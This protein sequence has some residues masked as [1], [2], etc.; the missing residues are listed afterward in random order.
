MRPRDVLRSINSARLAALVAL[1]ALVSVAQVPARQ[2]PAELPEMVQARTLFDALD[3]EQAIPMLDRAIM[4][5]EPAAVRDPAV[6]KSLV[7]A[8]EMRARARFGTG[9][10]DGAV[11]DFRA[12]LALNP[13]FT[14]GEGV[15]PRV[16][17]LLDEVKSSTVGILELQ[18]TPGDVS[19]QVDGVAVP[20]SGGKVS[21]A[22]GAHSIKI[23]RPGYKSAEQPVIVTAGQVVPLQLTLE[24]VS[25]VLTVVSSPPD[26]EVFVNGVSRGRTG[27]G[28]VPASLA[29]VPAQ[30]GV[31]ASLVSQPLVI[32]DIPAGTLQVELRR[33]CYA[34][35]HR[36]LPVEG[37]SDVMLDPVKLAP[38]MGALE[39][40]SEPAGATVW[41]DGEQKGLAPITMES[42]CAGTHTIEFRGASGRAVERVVLEAGGKVSVKGRVRP[43]F[44]LLSAPVTG[45]TPDPRLAV[46]RAFAS[47]TNVVLY[48]PPSDAVKAALDKEPV[49]DEWFGLVPGQDPSG[50][51]TERRSRTD[52]LA[53][54]FES[55]G[56]A[57]V[58]PTRPGS[59][60]MQIAL[61]VPGALQPDVLTVVLDQSD[62]VQ[63][64]IS[65]LD[66][67][68]VLS[69]PSLGL[70]VIDVLDV[71]GVVIVDL[72]AGQPGA[73]AGLKPGEILES[74]DGTSVTH[75]A[76][77]DARL[78]SHQPGEKVTLTV[79]AAGANGAS[80]QVP[81]TL[82]RAAAL[83]AGTDRFMPSNAIVAV[84]RSRLAGATEPEDQA[85][86][87]LNLG[88]A[89]LRAGDAQGARSALEKAS[90]PPGPGVSKGTVEYLLAEAAE[91]A[92][93]RGAAAL[94]YQSAA[95]AEGRLSAD[96]PLVKSLA[97][98]AL[99]RLK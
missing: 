64:A 82:T 90:L 44:A 46:E 63:T 50:S 62:S 37:M 16:V 3:Y 56:I 8:Y 13:S 79:R 40:D 28:P 35:E 77:L 33:P 47:S 66:T 80:R 81:V 85:V 32:G 94:A 75:A 52:N 45:S 68:L 53:T 70:A 26:V 48:A 73:Q 59:T 7:S 61:A 6:R 4:L 78:A 23:T 76:D 27:S 71:K 86:V 25:T 19:V 30:L 99:E 38:A 74:V 34:T 95:Q 84:L 9:N 2:A 72:E 60:E 31:P 14:L 29:G 96:G 93:D 20:S 57:W 1:F 41:I 24:R 21:L 83:L 10:R 87:Q 18:T 51:A 36:Q 89:L 55:Q 43:A 15:S 88:A 69:K 17:A 91:A 98:R 12:V 5:L 65:R 49:N 67:P 58:K 39:V 22:T 54:A 11:S 92:G 97:T 42:A